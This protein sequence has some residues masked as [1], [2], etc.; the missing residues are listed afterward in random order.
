MTDRQLSMAYFLIGL[1]ML[2]FG[3]FLWSIPAGFS[4]TGALVALMGVAG[5]MR[6]C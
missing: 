1:A 3:V 6:D 5:Y 2:C 4:V